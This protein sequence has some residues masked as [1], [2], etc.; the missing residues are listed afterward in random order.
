MK[1]QFGR[2]LAEMLM[3][4]EWRNSVFLNVKGM[5]Q[6]GYLNELVHNPPTV[7]CHS[8]TDCKNSNNFKSA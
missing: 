6:H 1:G 2:H 8:E 7:Q 3:H 4:S 5:C